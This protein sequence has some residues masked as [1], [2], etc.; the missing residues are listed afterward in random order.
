LNSNDRNAFTKAI[1]APVRR[2]TNHTRTKRRQQKNARLDINWNI[3]AHP[4]LSPKD[5]LSLQT[6]GMGVAERQ[7]ARQHH[8]ELFFSALGD[9]KF[10]GNNL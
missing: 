10:V 1:V 3:A 4:D 5:D 9:N 8:D 2:R 6:L 7:L